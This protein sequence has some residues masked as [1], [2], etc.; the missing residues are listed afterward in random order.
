MFELL[1]IVETGME[2]RR[3]LLVELA[4]RRA[5]RTIQCVQRVMKRSDALSRPDAVQFPLRDRKPV[6]SHAPAFPTG[7]AGDRVLM[8]VS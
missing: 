4:P 1:S 3:S 2:A 5:D 7:R 8:W 6:A